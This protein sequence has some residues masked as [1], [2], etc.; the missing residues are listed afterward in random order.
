MPRFRMTPF[1]AA[2]TLSVAFFAGCKSAPPEEE[3]LPKNKL[4]ALTTSDR[5]RNEGEDLKAQGLKLRSEGKERE[6]N[7]LIK[8]GEA[9]L[10]ESE[11]MKE[12]GIMLKD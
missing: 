11:R 6:G 8:Q 4:E 5:L 9:K 7:A 1:L 10:V 12:K 3:T 2:A